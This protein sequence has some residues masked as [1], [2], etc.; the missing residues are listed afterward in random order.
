MK[1]YFLIT[2]LIILVV[3]ALIGVFIRSDYFKGAQNQRLLEDV[4]IPKLTHKNKEYSIKKGKVEPKDKEFS[5]LLS[6]ASFYQWNKEDPLFSSPDFNPE[7][8]AKSVLALGQQQQNLLKTIKSSQPVYPV[9]FLSLLALVASDTQD[10]LNQ[11]SDTKAKNLISNQKKLA[12]AYEKNIQGL[13][14]FNDTKE[15]L[16]PVLINIQISREVLIRDFKKIEENAKV[17]KEEIEKRED[18]L[19]GKE[20][21]I[22]PVK[23]GKNFSKPEDKEFK[24][25]KPPEFLEKSLVFNLE[26]QKPP[27]RKIT[28]PLRVT[29]PCFG[30]GD[31]FS[32]KTH[33]FYVADK[34]KELER[35]NIPDLPALNIR[36]ATEIYFRPVSKESILGGDEYLTKL[37]IPYT[38]QN[39]T[40]LYMCTY[41]GYLTEISEMNSFLATEKPILANLDLSLIPEDVKTFFGEAKRFENDFF[42]EQYA[43]YQ[44]L[45]TLG[46]YYAYAYRLISES[47]DANWAGSLEAVKDEFLKRSL[48]IK[49]KLGDLDLL[50]NNQ[51]LYIRTANL[52]ER[53][54]PH[55]DPGYRKEVF[56][57]LRGAYGLMYLPFSPSIWRSSDNLE[58]LE[59]IYVKGAVGWD[60]GFLSYHQAR[61]RYSKEDIEKW[62]TP[63][64]LEE[65]LNDFKD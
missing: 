33:Y 51:L 53:L 28:G 56:Y 39:V 9:E 30:W 38:T 48:N 15:S 61:E 17:L 3:I 4:S 54:K 32:F 7:G 8:F 64:M 27:V 34:N 63:P 26:G 21:C 11:P 44:D 41:L 57:I 59:K 20:V 55:E 49:R 13:I 31:N 23:D 50:F 40:S 6:L 14:K 22:R 42:S 37:N 35:Q 60:S 18:C 5:K 29:T 10:F 58:Y 19:L 47:S 46:D 16:N 2:F 62:F 52:R 36:L 25:E 45:S 65:R 1:K 24:A 12:D 43:S